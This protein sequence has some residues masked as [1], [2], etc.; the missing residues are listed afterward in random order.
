MVKTHPL[1]GG[2]VGG[3]PGFSGPGTETESYRSMSPPID[4]RTG[5]M[6]PS[7]FS[8]GGS[9]MSTPRAGTFTG[10]DQNSREGQTHEIDES[11]REAGLRYVFIVPFLK[12]LFLLRNGC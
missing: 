8:S 11:M 12:F 2:Y 5:M 9:T 6:V 4:E 7:V 3:G 1:E 10:Y